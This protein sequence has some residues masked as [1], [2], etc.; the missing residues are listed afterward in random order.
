MRQYGFE[1]VRSS[2]RNLN[3]QR[4]TESRLGLAGIKIALRTLNAIRG[5]KRRAATEGRRTAPR[6]SRH[7]TGRPG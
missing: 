5:L 3:R 7:A 6:G 2:M 1:A 4:R